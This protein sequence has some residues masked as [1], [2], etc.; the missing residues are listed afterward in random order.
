AWQ[1]TGLTRKRWANAVEILCYMAAIEGS[2][3]IHPKQSTI[4]VK[5][6]MS[7]RTVKRTIRELVSFEILISKRRGTT[8]NSYAINYAKLATIGV[9]DG[10]KVA[11]QQGQNGPS[12]RPNW[13]ISRAKLAHQHKEEI[14][15]PEREFIS[16]STSIANEEEV[17]I[18][19][20]NVRKH[21]R[22]APTL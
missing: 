14:A 9:V 6:R 2:S 10:P 19:L 11:Q 1:R 13:P 21:F 3:G 18:F 20:Q 17:E 12:A 5:C 8:A 15:L 7:V 22:D 4:A 16:S